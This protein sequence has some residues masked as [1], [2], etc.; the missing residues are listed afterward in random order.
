MYYYHRMAP[1]WHDAVGADGGPLKSLVLNDM[2]L[3]PIPGLE[4]V[5]VLEVGAGNGYLMRRLADRYPEHRFERLVISDQARPLVDLARRHF[6]IEGAEYRVIDLSHAL[7]FDDDSFD[8]VVADMVLHEL[9]TAM[10]RRALGELRRVLRPGGRLLGSVF[11]PRYVD[12]LAR[13]GQLRRAPGGVTVLPFFEDLYT[14]IVRRRERAYH[15]AFQQWGRLETV[16]NKVHV[17]PD[18][19]EALPG[20][21]RP[22][23]LPIALS[24]QA[25]PGDL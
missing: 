6:P 16:F 18:Y 12:A 24:F 20:L 7:P 10:L 4:G 9:N 15:T 21:R 23:R 19:F 5:A 14:P 2:A 11:H 1:A 22:D 25:T 8:F 13:S 3:D 17:P